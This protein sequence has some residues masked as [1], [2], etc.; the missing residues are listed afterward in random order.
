MNSPGRLLDVLGMTLPVIL[1]GQEIIGGGGVSRIDEVG[2][3]IVVGPVRHPGLISTLAI[4]EVLKVGKL[5][6]RSDNGV[7]AHCAGSDDILTP[8]IFDISIGAEGDGEG[9][10]LVAQQTATPVLSCSN[11]GDIGGRSTSSRSLGNFSAI[12]GE[13]PEHGDFETEGRDSLCDSISKV[14][15]KLCGSIRGTYLN[16]GDDRDD[17]TR[18]IIHNAANSD[19]D[20]NILTLEVVNGNTGIEGNDMLEEL[21]IHLSSR[22]LGDILYIAYGNGVGPGEDTVAVLVHEVQSLEGM[23]AYSG[24][25]RLSVCENCNGTGIG[26]LDSSN[27][28]LV[29]FSHVH[30]TGLVGIVIRHSRYSFY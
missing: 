13:H 18:V 17:I 1:D 27:T 5:I 2:R 28:G 22:L 24:T 21:V 8:S 26:S 15:I 12:G 7:V 10:R 9:V 30:V 19:I 20:G 11:D 4:A 25:S 3:L 6:S 16:P 23:S 14:L 29:I